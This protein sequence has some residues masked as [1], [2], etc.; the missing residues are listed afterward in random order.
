MYKNKMSYSAVRLCVV[1]PARCG[2]AIDYN[3]TDLPRR[4]TVRRDS[5]L[6]VVV[7]R[8]FPRACYVVTREN[9]RQL[10]RQAAIDC[11]NKFFDELVLLLAAQIKWRGQEY[12]I[13]AQTVDGSAHSVAKQATVHCRFLNSVVLFFRRVE[14]FFTTLVSNE[15]DAYEK[16]A[17]AHITNVWMILERFSK[18]G[19]NCLAALLYIS[20]KILLADHLLSCKR[21]RDSRRVAHK[22]MPVLKVAAFIPDSFNNSIRAEQRADWLVTRR[23]ALRHRH[24]VRDDVLLLVRHH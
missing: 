10:A 4:N 20:E 14:G 8:R 3:G 19:A 6:C 15:F 12:M 24:D 23:Q 7:D 1:L 5:A 9:L 2:A 17:P 11:S 22:C 13:T 21:C 16:P 18:F